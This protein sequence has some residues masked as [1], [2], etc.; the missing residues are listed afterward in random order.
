MCFLPDN[1]FTGMNVEIKTRNCKSKFCTHN[2]FILACLRS[3][4]AP[5][6]RTHLKF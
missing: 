6:Q 4:T 3:P 1:T 5:K 2:T